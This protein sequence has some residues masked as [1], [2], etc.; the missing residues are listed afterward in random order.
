MQ[1]NRNDTQK[2][3]PSEISSWLPIATLVPQQ[4]RRNLLVAESLLSPAMDERPQAR[5]WYRVVTRT[6]TAQKPTCRCK[7]ESGE[8][9]T[10]STLPEALHAWH[11]LVSNPT[12]IPS[13]VSSAEDVG[14]P[15]TGHVQA[16]ARKRSGR[17]VS[18]GSAGCARSEHS[19]PPRWI[20]R[21]DNSAVLLFTADVAGERSTGRHRSLGS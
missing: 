11:R 16:Q 17:D 1:R 21:D 4:R 19:V 15:F 3:P 12:A 18:L 5:G 8:P 2:V 13:E 7:T 20:D 14:V 9:M 10:D 6:M